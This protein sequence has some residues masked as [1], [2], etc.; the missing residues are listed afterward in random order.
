[1]HMR[2]QSWACKKEKIKG[3]RKKGR[4]KGRKQMKE[5]EFLA[6][7]LDHEYEEYMLLYRVGGT[8]WV[9]DHAT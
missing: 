4:M 7:N 3:R 1:M 2:I 5:P 6:C 8:C 9:T